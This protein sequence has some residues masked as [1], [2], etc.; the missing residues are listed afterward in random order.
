MVYVAVKVCEVANYPVDGVQSSVSI[1]LDGVAVS[2]GHEYIFDTRDCS[3]V[4]MRIESDA[5]VPYASA[6]HS[7]V[8]GIPFLTIMPLI[9]GAEHGIKI[10]VSPRECRFSILLHYSTYVWLLSSTLE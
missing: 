7:S 9:Q 2:A 8:M 5:A 4:F 10:W 3:K 1:S 6:L